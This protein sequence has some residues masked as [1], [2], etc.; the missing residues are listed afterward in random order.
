MHVTSWACLS[1]LPA[2][3]GFNLDKRGPRHET[4]RD[5]RAEAGR[6]GGEGE[7][8]KNTAE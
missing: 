2:Y 3:P 5:S 8:P 4:K 7:L 6:R 1:L